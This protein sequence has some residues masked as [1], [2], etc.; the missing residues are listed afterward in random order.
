MVFSEELKV[1]VAEQK[2]LAEARIA[3][4]GLSN[5]ITVELRDYRDLEGQ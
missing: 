5:L 4:A 3:K 2:E 1:L